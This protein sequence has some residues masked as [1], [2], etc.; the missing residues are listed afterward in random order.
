MVSRVPPPPNPTCCSDSARAVRVNPAVS[1]L[2]A[3]PALSSPGIRS[4]LERAGNAVVHHGLKRWAFYIRM[5][6]PFDA[7]TRYRAG[8]PSRDNH[9]SDRSTTSRRNLRSARVETGAA[10]VRPVA[11]SDR[12]G[13]ARAV[14]IS[15]ERSAIHSHNGCARPAGSRIA[16]RG[17]RRPPQPGGAERA[18]PGGAAGLAGGGRDPTLPRSHSTTFDSPS[19]PASPRPARPRLVPAA[20]AARARPESTT[21]RPRRVSAH[22]GTERPRSARSPHD[23]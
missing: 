4:G 12:T 17:M 9:A 19:V 8:R 6:T 11:T 13:N 22:A 1:S 10:A 23:R 3:F 20:G 14:G 2:T 21:P 16:T 18:R 7:E 5:Y 15:R